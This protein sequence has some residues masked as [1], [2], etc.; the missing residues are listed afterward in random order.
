MTMCFRM[1]RASQSSVIH[2]QQ[3]HRATCSARAT[4]AGRKLFLSEA[5]LRSVR[6]PFYSC[7]IPTSR[8]SSASSAEQVTSQV[9]RNHDRVS[10]E[11]ARNPNMTA[12]VDRVA[13]FTVRR[14]ATCSG[15]EDPACRLCTC[16]TTPAYQA[17]CS[18]D[19]VRTF[20]SFFTSA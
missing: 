4:I 14:L 12:G 6:S 5:V 8:L 17:P 11:I 20:S 16:V 19:T 15:Q 18:A 2:S 9:R 3:D 10:V 13:E 7:L 1:A